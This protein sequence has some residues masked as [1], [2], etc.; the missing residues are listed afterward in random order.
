M[1][2]G[3][4]NTAAS[5]GEASYWVKFTSGVSDREIVCGKRRV[6][7]PPLQRIFGFCDDGRRN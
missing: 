5:D 1:E 6:H 3:R 4:Q 7:C 2:V